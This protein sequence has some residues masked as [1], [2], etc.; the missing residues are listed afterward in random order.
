M[1][2]TAETSAMGLSRLAACAVAVATLCAALPAAAA[3]LPEAPDC[4]MLPA[5]SVWHAD[6]SALPV[7]PLSDTYVASIGAERGLK[8]DFGAGLWDGGPIGIPY[9]V[10][11][12]GQ[13]RV[14]VSFSYADES[15]PGPYPIPSDAKIEGGADSDGDRH[16][17]V[18]DRDAC[19][20]YELFDAHRE[21]DGSWDAGSGAVFDLTSNALRPAGWT[22]ADAAGLPILPGLVRYDEVASGRI[23]HAIR[24]TV[25]RSQSAYL[26]PARHHA[27]SADTSLPPMGLRLRLKAGV[28]I[29]GFP[30]HDRV[31]LQA[32][33]TY[34]LIVADNGSPWF[35]SGVPD[36]RW[37]NDILQLLG[38]IRGS[39]FEAV[40]MSSLMVDPNSGAV[41][42][43]AIDGARLAGPDR[44]STA[45]ALS[46]FAYPH[47]APIAV[48]AAA[49]RFPDAL[50]AAPLAAA[51]G[52]PVLLNP[53]D[54]LADSVGGEIRRLGARTIYLMGGA[55][56]QS[57]RVEAQLREIAG[58]RD[59]IRLGGDDRHGT[60]AAAAEEAVALW[61]G[62]GDIEAGWTVVV[63]LGSHPHGE[64][65]AWPDALAAGPLA[66]YSRAPL[67]LVSHDAVPA[68]T[69]AA[70]A[71]LDPERII[72]A[73]GAAAVT[74]GVLDQLS[75]S[76]ATVR[77]VGGP[78]R[79]E[80]AALLAALALDARPRGAAGAGAIVATGLSF[81]DGL[82]AGAAAQ[83]AGGL[84]L[85]TARDAASDAAL[86]F[87]GDL[88]APWLRIAGGRAAISDPAAAALLAAAG[89]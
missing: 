15:D 77:R 45:V 5:T 87:L 6:V 88:D 21:P 54:A 44:V 36:P 57:D 25:P 86:S 28:D 58:V 48:V 62:A 22:S 24:V 27:G 60:A 47:G 89:S 51:G 16:V 65:R 11:G 59:V 64:D 20:L 13:A 67:L 2:A 70:L 46:R 83:A 7:H 52:G 68:A 55:G 17:L 79:Y 23:D 40:E 29:S 75:D 10:V 72:V 50:A 61:R 3:P 39:D 84:L 12:G 42:S 34:G 63:A 76:G 37:N 9:T 82:A 26:W 49:H 35:I 33:K 81:P 38:S 30:A 41:R 74:D 18:I 71:E 53:A 43:A 8:A 14:P 1:R 31:I 19:R 73:G 32:L 85:L 78:S 69:M 56:A 4:P 80:T 66:G